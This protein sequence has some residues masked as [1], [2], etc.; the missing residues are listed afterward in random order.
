MLPPPCTGHTF[1]RASMRRAGSPM[2]KQGSVLAT[3]TTAKSHVE[4]VRRAASKLLDLVAHA[5]HTETVFSLPE[6]ESSMGRLRRVAETLRAGPSPVRVAH[7]LREQVG[8]WGAWTH[9]IQWVMSSMLFNSFCC[10][11]P[12]HHLLAIK[13]CQLLVASH[14]FKARLGP[15]SVCSSLLDPKLRA[16]HAS[17]AFLRVGGCPEIV[18]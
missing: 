4:G 16:Q 8:A 2:Q 11:C 7:V 1:D 12:L 9:G 5:A 10:Q 18:C 17:H 15:T 3:A 13:F 14:I 6:T